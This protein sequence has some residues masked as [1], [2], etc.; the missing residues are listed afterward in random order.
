M[1]VTTSVLDP[2]RRLRR[3]PRQYAGEQSEHVGLQETQQHV[4]T[5]MFIWPQIDDQ[6]QRSLA[7]AG[8]HAAN[9]SEA[10]NVRTA[11]NV[12][13]GEPLADPVDHHGA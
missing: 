4:V 9:I 10:I 3:E 7:T 8:V 13:P 12:W 6:R 5:G 2:L 1:A 11:V